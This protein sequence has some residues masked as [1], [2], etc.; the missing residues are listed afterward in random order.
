MDENIK[1]T[2]DLVRLCRLALSGR[3]QDVHLFA[4][5]L[6][7]RYRDTVPELAREIENLLVENPTRNSPLRRQM[8][9]PLPVDLDSRL[10]LLRVE[11]EPEPEV[12]P[13]LRPN[14]EKSLLQVIEEHLQRD[15]LSR[16][17]LF[18]SRTLLFTG[19][20][21]VGK[22]LVARWL[23]CKLKRPLLLLDLSAV[24][25]SFLGRTGVNLRYV[26]DYAKASE[27]ILLLDEFDAIAKRRDD[28]S[29]IGELKRLVTVLLQEIDDWPPKG[30]LIAATNHP[31]LL[32]PAV[33]RR[34]DVVVDFP[35]PDP[36]EVQK[37]VKQFLGPLV[38]E[39]KPFLRILAGVFWGSSY[40]DVERSLLQ[41]RRSCALGGISVEDQMK[42]LITSR[43]RELSRKDRANLAI[44]LSG[45]GLSQREISS[46]TGV[47]RDT[48]R[49]KRK[50]FSAR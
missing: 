50:G 21:G 10:Q 15:R 5:R 18:P 38:E 34:F 16:V 13:I 37:A 27:G 47:S 48:I 39:S 33:W 30:L 43:V 3:S 25:S 8:S 26:L 44:S 4:H 2:Q 11:L 49:R 19:P 20:P 41:A 7:R 14:V 28:A 17:G 40:N 24:M 6:A 45:A 29:D 1:V 42:N 46:L 9:S 23:A 12:S 22:T 36:D 35:L 32:D 31:E